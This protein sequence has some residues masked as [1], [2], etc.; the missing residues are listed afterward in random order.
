MSYVGWRPTSF[1]AERGLDDR[2]TWYDSVYPA[3][4][5]M[6]PNCPLLFNEEGHRKPAYDGVLCAVSEAAARSKGLRR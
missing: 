1:R 6:K 3:T 4:M 2:Q 5:P